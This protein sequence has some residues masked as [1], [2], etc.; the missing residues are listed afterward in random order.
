[1]VAKGL[2]G[3][4]PTAP[5][6]PNLRGGGWG[7]RPRPRGKVPVTPRGPQG[8]GGVVCAPR[9]EAA[10]QVTYKK[11]NQNQKTKTESKREVAGAGGDA[12][13]RGHPGAAA[14]FGDPGASLGLGAE[15]G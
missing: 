5:A 11:K 4:R 8:A 2:R 9:G 15:G 10:F 7:P 13:P 14:S 6:G 3:L 12:V 1:M